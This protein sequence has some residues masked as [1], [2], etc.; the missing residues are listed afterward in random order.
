M[1]SPFLHILLTALGVGFL[2]VS[3]YDIK[4]VEGR[5]MS[6]TLYPSDKVIINRWAYGLQLP[7]VDRYLLHWNNV[8][9]GELVYFHDPVYQKPAVKR[10][11]AGVQTEI[12]YN[13]GELLIGDDRI[14]LSA[15]L[16]S[17]FVRLHAI[18]EGKVFLIG[19]NQTVSFDSRHYGLVDEGEIEGR[20]VRLR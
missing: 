3:M 14:P 8:A 4:S 19:D 10:C 16:Q 7:F 11:L 5:S 9:P 6:P 17:S 20:I 15:S 13:N 12:F 18:P 2:A 1:K